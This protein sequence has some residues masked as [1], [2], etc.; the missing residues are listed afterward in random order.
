MDNTGTYNMVNK[1]TASLKKS[2][3]TQKVNK[4]HKMCLVPFL[5]DLLDKEGR[6]RRFVTEKDK[7]FWNRFLSCCFA[8][9][10]FDDSS[11]PMNIPI[12]IG[13]ADTFDVTNVVNNSVVYNTEQRAQLISRRVTGNYFWIALPSGY[14]LNRAENLNFAGDAIP[15]TGF[16]QTNMVIKN[17]NYIVYYLKARVPFNSTYKIILK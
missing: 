7:V 8:G 12:Y 11:T 10:K 14:A 13:T 2:S 9:L 17:G 1:Y 6:L 3:M 4:L 16:T 5:K 15:S